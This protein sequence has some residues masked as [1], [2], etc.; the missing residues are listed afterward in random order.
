MNFGARF[1]DQHFCG[2]LVNPEFL[3]E[4]E[5]VIPNQCSFTLLSWVLL[6]ERPD[7]QWNSNVEVAC[8]GECFRAALPRLVVGT[9][10]RPWVNQALFVSALNG[11]NSPDPEGGLPVL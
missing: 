5:G 9:W 6:S 7:I 4:S 3:E 10:R 11:S 1:W 8:D 2:Y